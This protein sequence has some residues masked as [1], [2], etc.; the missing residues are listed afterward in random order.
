[1]GHGTARK[2]EHNNPPGRYMINIAKLDCEL[3]AFLEN[4]LILVTYSTEQVQQ[5]SLTHSMKVWIIPQKN[6]KHS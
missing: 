2:K 5:D 3:K 6:L 4:V 1:M